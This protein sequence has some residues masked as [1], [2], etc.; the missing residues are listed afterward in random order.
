MPSPES[1]AVFTAAAVALLIVPG[2]AVLYVVARSVDQGRA[3]GLVSTLGVGLGSLIHVAA[4]AAGL[5]AVLAAS[6][7]AF[8]AVKL[9]GAGYLVF[10]GIRRIVRPEA[11]EVGPGTAARSRSS[12]FRQGV[13]VNVLNPKTA[14]FFLTFLPQFVD[15]ARGPAAVQMLIL[16]GAFV[17]MGILSDGLY[18]L[19]AGSISGW[20]RSRPRMVTAQRYVT[21][22]TLI[23][24]GIFAAV[25]GSKQA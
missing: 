3:A 9:A 10:L 24:L 13:V 15:P 17:A 20:L 11:V 23:G 19:G 4:A 18:A 22:T 21:G 1:F 7:T 5:S 14:L 12:I 16:G 6:A 2:P 25:S 8:T